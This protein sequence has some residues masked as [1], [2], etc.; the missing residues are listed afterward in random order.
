MLVTLISWTVVAFILLSFGDMLIAL[1][2]K[3]CRNNENYNLIDKLLLGLCLLIIPLSI[4]SLWLPSN[5]YFL[6]VVF[7]V[8]I[9]YWIIR[10]PQAHG[11][12]VKA[13]ELFKTSFSTSR[14]TILIVGILSLLFFFSW[15]HDVYDAAFYHLQNVRWNEE[16]AV[17]PGLANLDDRFGF[18]SNYFLLSAIFSFRFILSDAIYPLHP[19]I[20]TAITCW[21]LIELIRSHYEIKRVIIFLSYTLL[22]WS[23]IYFLGN[24]S[25]DILPNFIAFYIIARIVLYPEILKKNHLI[26]IL[27]P[28][29]LIT[30]KL[31]FFPLGL[32]SL[33]SLYCM[34]K[35]RNYKTITILFTIS[36]F[37]LIPWL[38]RNVI[39]SGYLVFPISAIDLFNFDW[40]VPH[41][42][43]VKEKEYIFTVGYYY[44]R[45][46]FLHPSMSMRDPLFINILT[47]IICLLT[48]IS[49]LVI[50]F[51]FIKKRRTMPAHIYLLYAIFL[52]SILAC[53]TS[54]PD[55]RF[56]SGI[57]CACIFTG[58]ILLVSINKYKLIAIPVGKSLSILFF[59]GI[60]FWSAVRLFTFS[61]EADISITEMATNTIIRPH[62][63][64][65]R[66]KAIGL[67]IEEKFKPYPI[68]NGIIIQTSSFLPYDMPIPATIHSHYAKFLPVR[69][70]EARGTTLQEGFRAKEG[71]K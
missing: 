26:G 11:L 62:S 54:G 22:F 13:K 52:L 51:I 16:Y 56:I 9:I 57:L 55:V 34:A 68:N 48:G 42:V 41:E 14:I 32:I 61:S 6:A 60:I 71:C 43:A 40:K 45:T 47:N 24:T 36:L 65:D 21:L 17:V 30:I 20:V 58:G 50:S 23:S 39:I 7:C 10:W 69:C 33:Y 49:L 15:Q 64:A 59:A 25:T 53:A 4:W 70:L 46:A 37:I 18:N 28:V 35:G 27:L 12:Y 2:N 29:F 5:H 19:L 31:S 67:I 38:I 8:S 63:I 1:Y 66:Q 44:L 3:L